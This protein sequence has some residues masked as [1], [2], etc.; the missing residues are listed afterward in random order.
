M[1]AGHKSR[2]FGF[3]FAQLECL[4]RVVCLFTT[5]VSLSLPAQPL[6]LSNY[7]PRHAVSSLSRRIIVVS[8]SRRRVL[9]TLIAS[10][11][12]TVVPYLTNAYKLQL[13]RITLCF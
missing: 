8:P 5:S 1:T 12:F 10:C 13:S 6:L 7:F 9:C 11:Y 2:S 3:D 4:E